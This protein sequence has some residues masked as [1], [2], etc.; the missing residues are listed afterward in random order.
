MKRTRI[1]IFLTFFSKV[2][3]LVA[4]VSTATN[5]TTL[6][7]MY[8]K[9]PITKFEGLFRVVTSFK[10]E[11]SEI[12]GHLLLLS[13]GPEGGKKAEKDQNTSSGCKLIDR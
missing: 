1:S 8:R 3:P 11:L 4:M 7:V 13:L 10:S 2:I 6:Q 9:I 5:K 12:K